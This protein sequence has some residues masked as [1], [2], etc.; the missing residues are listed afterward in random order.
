MFYVVCRDDLKDFPQPDILT[1]IGSKLPFQYMQIYINS[2]L[3]LLQSLIFTIY[4]VNRMGGFSAL[5]VVLWNHGALAGREEVFGG[6]AHG[7]CC[8]IVGPTTRLPTLTAARR[9]GI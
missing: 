2:R 8:F 9:H 7:P 5:L 3:C 6:A 4:D 1:D